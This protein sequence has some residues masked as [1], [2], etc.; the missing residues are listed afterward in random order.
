M[1]AG[2]LL[3]GALG[4]LVLDA[5]Q[6]LQGREQAGDVLFVPAQTVV[7]LFVD[8]V[9]GVAG[10]VGEIGQLR[11]ENHRLAAQNE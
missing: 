1:W 4:L 5:T 10:T 6:R 3:F 9:T 8:G 7:A 11:Q 2:A